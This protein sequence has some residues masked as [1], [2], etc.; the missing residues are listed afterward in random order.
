MIE[1]GDSVYVPAGQDNGDKREDSR[2]PLG[3]WLRMEDPGYDDAYNKQ[4]ELEEKW[5]ELREEAGD[6]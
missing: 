5:M 6:G 4:S 3:R 1:Y 2:G